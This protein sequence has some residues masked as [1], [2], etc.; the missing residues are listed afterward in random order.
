MS[1][2]GRLRHRVQILKR[3]TPAGRGRG[4][5]MAGASRRCEI[6]YL[7][8]EEA[9]RERAE[10]RVIAEITMRADAETRTWGADARLK[11]LN[12][13]APLWAEFDLTGEPVIDE[14]GR[15]L[16]FTAVKGAT[17]ADDE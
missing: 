2:A 12:L 7:K 9:V 5:W 1:W 11:Q 14:L 4:A 6:R 13:T 3:D 8:G 16:T 10:G 17:R 15:W